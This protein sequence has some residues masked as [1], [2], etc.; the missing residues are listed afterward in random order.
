[1]SRPLSIT[2]GRPWLAPLAGHSDLALRTLCREQGAAVACTEMVSAKGLVYGAR[3]RKGSSPSDDLL[4]TTPPVGTLPDGFPAQG[5]ADSPL[6]VQLFGEDPD[7]LGEAASMLADRGF[8]YFDLNLGCS[9]PKVIKTGAGAALARDINSAAAAAR[10][11]IR[12]SEGRVGF[13]IRLGW[14][15][16]EENYLE[17]AKA[18]ENEGAAW[19]TLHPR[20]SRQGFT[21]RADWAALDKLKKNVNIPVIASGDLFDAASAARCLR[22]SGVDALMFARGALNNPGI[23]KELLEVLE[24]GGREYSLAEKAGRLE[25]LALRHAELARAMPGQPPRKKRGEARP[26]GSLLKMRGAIPRYIKEMPGSRA[27]RVALS[28]CR[29]WDEFYALVR[30][31]FTGVRETAKEAAE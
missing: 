10:A 18:L 28:A 3:S 25:A 4:L 13:K 7:F 5:T 22:E 21:G 9:V 2:P 14:S 24:N 29:D 15:R 30:D 1:M 31:F 12:A 23:F 16:E 20:Y 8:E 19:I 27:F 26:D 11:M 17:L 6:V